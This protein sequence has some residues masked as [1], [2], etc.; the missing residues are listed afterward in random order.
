[1][2]TSQSTETCFKIS[3][4]KNKTGMEEER[5]RKKNKKEMWETVSI[6]HSELFK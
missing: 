3:Q 5:K 1:L 4:D 2:E 6:E